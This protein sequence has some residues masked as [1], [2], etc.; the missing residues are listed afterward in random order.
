MQIDSQ[1]LSVIEVQVYPTEQIVDPQLQFS[2]TFSPSLH[3]VSTGTIHSLEA[4]NYLPI[5]HF[6]RS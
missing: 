1:V 4:V 5:S 2:V 3:E 6:L